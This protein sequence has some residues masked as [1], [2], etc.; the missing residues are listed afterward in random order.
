MDDWETADWDALVPLAVPKG[1]EEQEDDSGLKKSVGTS[2]RDDENDWL[3]DQPKIEHVV[4]EEES[5]VEGEP[6]IIVNLTLLSNGTIHSKFDRNSVNDPD[7]ARELRLKIEANYK[8]YARNP[9]LA[10]NKTVIP[11][12]TNVWRD[13]LVVL[14]NE[15][16]GHYFSPIFP[17]KLK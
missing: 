11:A 4:E 8:D 12:A 6:M 2:K 15:N 17:P 3:A 16:E 14:R 1:E 5:S 10:M 13:A 7:G 9:E